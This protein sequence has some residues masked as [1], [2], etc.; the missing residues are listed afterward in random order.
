MAWLGL[1]VECGAR[2]GGGAADHTA[3]MALG[4][5]C[6]RL[7][8]SG[9][10]V[11]RSRLCLPGTSSPRV[12]MPVVSQKRAE[13]CAPRARRVY[14]LA[15]CPPHPPW[16]V[17]WKL[18]I[19]EKNALITVI[20][21]GRKQ[22]ARRGPGAP[23]RAA[24]GIRKGKPN[25][26][27][28]I[29]D[30]KNENESSPFRQ[31]A[32]LGPRRRR[33]RARGRPARR[34]SLCDCVVCV[35]TFYL[36]GAAARSD[37]TQ[38]SQ[39]PARPVRAMQPDASGSHAHVA[40][41]ALFVTLSSLRSSHYRYLTAPRRVFLSLACHPQCRVKAVHAAALAWPAFCIR[42]PSSSS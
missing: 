24:R 7:L 20:D 23:A 14:E 26:R 17:W 6:L 5:A 37:L 15:S 4:E 30:K 22:L 29:T 19:D 33:A 10:F 18:Y 31:K 8:I 42:P 28:R 12:V 27:K 39:S 40:A 25:Y 2:A 21:L 16:T 35:D 11:A 32:T 38:R 1:W 3:R 41:R 36:L 34:A 9:A 13:R